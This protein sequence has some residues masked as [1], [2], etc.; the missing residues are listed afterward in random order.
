MVLF[1]LMYGLGLSTA[2]YNVLWLGSKK[3][4]HMSPFL[5]TKNKYICAIYS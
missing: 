2:V 3:R 4:A 1:L 5:L